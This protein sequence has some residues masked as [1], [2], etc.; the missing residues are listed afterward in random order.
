[1]SEKSKTVNE[2]IAELDEMIA[3]FDSDEFS[4]EEAL[5]KYKAASELAKEITKDLETFKNEVTV[6]KQKF[7]EG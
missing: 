1:M 4:I 5:E 7:D 3:W 2:K 6:L